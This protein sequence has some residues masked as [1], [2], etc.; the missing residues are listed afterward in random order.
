MRSKVIAGNWKMNNDL[1]ESQ[2]LIS[3]LIEG[4]GSEK[5]NCDVIICPPFTSLSL[6]ASLIKGSMIKLGAQN[7]YFEESGAFTGEVSAS[8]LKSVGCEFVILGHSERRTIFGETDAIINK[9]IKKALSSG[10]KP[11]FCVGE[12]LQER[13]SGVT[14][15][16]I[17]RQVNE[18]LKDLTEKDLETIII[19]YEPVWA[20]GTGRTATPE[21]A[22]EVHNFIRSL[23]SDKFSTASAE[24]MVIQYG[25]SVKPDNAK[26]LLSQKDIDGA[27]VGGACLKADSFIGIIKAA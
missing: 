20:I 19:A 12:T 25:G 23:I 9:K 22:Q 24:K 2:N 26:E 1:T 18:G 7:M 5:I 3:K 13:E 8:M 6:S 27:L 4:I 17:K 21:Q 11:I 10:L 14:N 15:S 16:I